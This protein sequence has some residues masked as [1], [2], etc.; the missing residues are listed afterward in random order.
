L[1]VVFLFFVLVKKPLKKVKKIAKIL[2][3]IPNNHKKELA[4]TGIKGPNPK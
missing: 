4:R 1:S 3:I 2:I